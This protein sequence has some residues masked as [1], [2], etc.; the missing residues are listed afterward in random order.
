MCLKRDNCNIFS[1]TFQF[2]GVDLRG[3]TT[4]QATQEIG[5][6]TETVSMLVQYNIESKW[7]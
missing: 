6:P 5:K 1:V 4:E 7:N 2:N 3:A